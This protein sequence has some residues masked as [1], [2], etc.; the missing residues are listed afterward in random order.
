MFSS[1]RSQVDD[2]KYRWELISN[3]HSPRTVW[4]CCYQSR[5]KS[6]C[7]LFRHLLSHLYATCT[8]LFHPLDQKTWK[9]I[10]L[11]TQRPLPSKKSG[12]KWSK[13]DKIWIKTPGVNGHVSL[14]Y[15]WSN[16]PKHDLIPGVNGASFCSLSLRLQRP[17]WN[18]LI[19]LAFSTLILRENVFCGM[20]LNM[21]FIQSWN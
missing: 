2:A 7:S 20:D 6:C 15:L 5:N 14:T 12:Q 18:L 8:S 9:S 13:V 3:M 19:F 17:R 21:V 10:H 1:N 11:P 16:W 4:S